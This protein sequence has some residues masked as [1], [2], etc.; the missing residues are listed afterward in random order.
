MAEASPNDAIWGI[1]LGASDEA[2]SD[3]RRWRGTNLLGQ[4]F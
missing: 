2:A 1:G 3:F 4:V